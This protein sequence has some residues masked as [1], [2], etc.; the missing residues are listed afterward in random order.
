[1]VITHGAVLVVD[2]EVEVARAH[3]DLL[4]GMG[5]RSLCESS[6]E[7][8]ESKLARCR[9]IDLVL[10]DIRMPR[11]DGL[12]LLRRIKLRRPEVGV[13]MATVVNDIE[14]AVTAI[15]SGAY[16]Y[17]L[18]PLQTESL[19]RTLDSFYTNRPKSLSDDLR[20]APFVTGCP[21][22]SD[23]FRQTKAFAE[24]DVP[25]LVLGETGTGKELVANMIH[26]LSPRSGERFLAVNMAALSPSLFESELF[27][28]CRG[29]FTGAVADRAGYFEES[30]A[31]TL[32]LD[33]IGE[34]TPD[35]QTKLLRVVQG[36]CFSRIG[37]TQERPIRA[38]FVIATNRDLEKD[39]REG[40]FRRDL[41][42]RLMNYRIDLPPL[43][44][45]PGD[46]A[47]LSRY[48][49]EKYSSQFGRS[50]EGFEP[51]ALR[52]FEGYPFPGNVRELE[53]IISSAVLL[54]QS[55]RI[56]PSTLPGYLK[57]L[58]DDSSDLESV[59]RRSILKA[60]AEC[61][62]NQTKAARKLGIARQTLNVLLKEYREQGYIG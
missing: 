29:A 6:P 1:M 52:L 47:L 62:G 28:Y 19:Q 46:V 25:V 42:Y 40:R 56:Q 16:N 14:K 20:F 31:G 23:I 26:A 39:V 49:L 44:N 36:R 43:R 57:V 12:Q 27:G 18:K 10:L 3:A 15:K 41:Y 8:V 7:K 34:L 4:E 5:Y 45:R 38:R 35:Q 11:F 33:E 2:D 24:T 53:G 58:A 61:D 51:E 21:A 32:F 59:R 13:I 17:L 30:G 60:L 55:T 48:F 22:F 37:E 54:E 9:D 50:I